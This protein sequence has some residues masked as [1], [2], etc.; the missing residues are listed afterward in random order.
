MDHRLTTGHLEPLL[1]K[2]RSTGVVTWATHH[3]ASSLTHPKMFDYFHTSSESFFF[4]PMVQSSHIMLYNTA[5]V[6]TKLM[7]PW[8][9]CALTQDCIDPIGAQSSGCRFNKKPLYRY[10]GCHRYDGSALNI[11]LGLMFKETSYVYSGGE[12]FFRQV[13]EGAEVEPEKISENSTVSTIVHGL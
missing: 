4:L 13:N 10:S 8:I 3:A 7:L 12:I 9:Q 11:V 1:Q 6:H 5:E 2:A